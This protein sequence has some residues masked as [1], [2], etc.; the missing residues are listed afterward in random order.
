MI[1]RVEELRGTHRSEPDEPTSAKP[2]RTVDQAMTAGREGHVPA[3]DDGHPASTE[4]PGRRALVGLCVVVLGC[5][6]VIPIRPGTATFTATVG[7]LVLV[8][9]LALT[10]RSPAAT[11]AAVLVD[12]MFV[13]FVAGALGHWPPALTTVLVCALP[14]L[15]LYAAGRR[16]VTLRPALPWFR[17][18]RLTPEAPW[19]GIAT[20]LLS[21]LALSVWALIVRP[22]PAQYLR[23]LQSLPLWLAALG[24]VGFALVNPIWEEMLYRGVLLTEL[25]RVWGPKVAVTLQAVLFGAAHY[26]GFPSGIAGM[27]MAACWGFA[28]GVMRLRSGGILVSYVVHV[29]ANAVIGVLAVT[30]LH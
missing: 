14:P 3:R 19:F 7:A 21:A 18:G 30:V 15:L 1:L 5:S 20:V 13:C 2:S 22:E 29:T 10:L 28:L 9:V 25:G 16:R 8:T 23:D 27:V 6:I 12:T 4:S 26:A 24:V 11:R 17:R